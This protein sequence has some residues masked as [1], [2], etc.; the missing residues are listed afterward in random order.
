MENVDLR[1]TFNRQTKEFVQV[2]PIEGG[3]WFTDKY[4]K[5]LENKI[6]GNNIV[7]IHFFHT[8]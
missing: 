1:K 7:L 8:N 4:V 3:I 5:W 2:S 6:L